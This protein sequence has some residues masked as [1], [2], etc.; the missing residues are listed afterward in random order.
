MQVK[1]KINTEKIE[2]KGVKKVNNVECTQ[3]H[4]TALCVVRVW[5]S[6]RVGVGRVY[7]WSDFEQTAQKINPLNV[8]T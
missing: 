3:D 4:T 5:K 7:R 8:I 1:F 2:W 6:W